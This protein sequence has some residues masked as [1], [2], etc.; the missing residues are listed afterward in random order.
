MALAV[1]GARALA[2]MQCEAGRFDNA[3]ASLSAMVS[4]TAA[5]V[6]QLQWSTQLCYLLMTALSTLTVSRQLRAA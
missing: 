3:Q 4:A 1:Q 5:A 6:V 2:L